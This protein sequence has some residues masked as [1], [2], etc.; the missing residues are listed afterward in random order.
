MWYAGFYITGLHENKVYFWKDQN[1]ND[2]EF[3]AFDTKKERDDFVDKYYHFMGSS[4]RHTAKITTP[5]MYK[6]LTES[7]YDKVLGSWIMGLR[8]KDWGNA[9]KIYRTAREAVVGELMDRCYQ[10]KLNKYPEAV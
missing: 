2:W 7:A 10:E 6:I 8:D 5:M 9:R 1:I 3:F 4:R